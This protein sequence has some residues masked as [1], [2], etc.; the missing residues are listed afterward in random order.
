MIFI[1]IH[2]RTLWTLIF[3]STACT[4]FFLSSAIFHS[5]IQLNW[6]Y[7]RVFV[8]KKWRVSINTFIVNSNKFNNETNGISYFTLQA[9]NSLFCDK[10]NSTNY[11]ITYQE[12]GWKLTD[13]TTSNTLGCRSW[14]MDNKENGNLYFTD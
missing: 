1:A 3:W 6:C 13:Q 4:Y 5:L 8:S 11:K 2:L 10:L 14:V 9:N 12:T 7:W